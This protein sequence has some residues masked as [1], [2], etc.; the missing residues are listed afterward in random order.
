MKSEW[1]NM[2]G[3]RIKMCIWYSFSP[4]D[5]V[6]INKSGTGRHVLNVLQS[7]HISVHQ[8]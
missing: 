3:D 2:H 1:N 4:Y 8:C 6:E 7:N 5:A